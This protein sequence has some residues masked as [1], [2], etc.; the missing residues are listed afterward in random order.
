LVQIAVPRAVLPLSLSIEPELIGLAL[1][2]TAARWKEST[3]KADAIVVGPGLGQIASAK[4]LVLDVLKRDKPVVIDADALNILS[5]GAAWPKGVNAR[6]V[7]TPHPGEMLRLGKLFGK[8]KQ[9]N[10]EAD[11]I[12][13]ATRAAKKFGQVIVL[14]GARTIVTDGDKI[15]INRTGD[16]SLSKAGTGDILTGI[17]ATL[18]A[19]EVD[20]FHAACTAVWLHGRAGEHAG[21]RLGPRSTTARDVVESIAA[22]I[23]DYQ[24]PFGIGSHQPQPR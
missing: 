9:T 6:C 15:Y 12:D 11:R 22:A 3:E 20:P 10:D 23:A 19:Q 13:T 21:M 4:R 7:L 2:A 8:T 18:L 16:S 5:A 1:P 24:S 14:K 17:T